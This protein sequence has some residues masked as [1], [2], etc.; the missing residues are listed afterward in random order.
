MSNTHTAVT[1]NQPA[2]FDFTEHNIRER[3]ELHPPALFPAPWASEWGFDEYGLW[4]S[5]QINDEVYRLRYI[6]PG[7]FLMGSPEDELGRDADEQQH[8]VEITQ[9]FWLGETTVTQALW[10]AVMGDNPSHFTSENEQLPVE[11]VDWF[12]SMDFCERINNLHPQLHLSLPSEA[13]WEYACRSGTQTAFNMGEE[14]NHDAVNFGQDFNSGKTADV[15]AYP[16]NAWGLK[17]MHGN[18]W[19]WCLD[20]KRDYPKGKAASQILKDPE[21]LPQ[22]VLRDEQGLIVYKRQEQDTEVRI[23]RG[24]SWFRRAAYCRSAQRDRYHPDP[25]SRSRGLRVLQVDSPVAGRPK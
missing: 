13:Q 18:V 25:R 16:A 14:L 22:S 3:W 12:Q 4:Q 7:N 19:E 8:P 10:Q 9:G 2:S 11:S 23:V 20:I 24:G 17:Q 6:P 1:S 15:N 5:L 21:V